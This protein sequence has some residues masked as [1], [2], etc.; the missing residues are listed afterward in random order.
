MIPTMTRRRLLLG[1]MAC[2]VCLAA[3][4]V[5]A[6]EGVPWGYAGERGPAAW[7]KLDPAY[8]SCGAGREQSPIDLDGALAAD[9]PAVVP[10]LKPVPLRVVHNGH[11]IEVD[12]AGGGR[13]IIGDKPYDL[14]QFH[15]HHPSEHVVAGRAFA[16]EMHLVH[17]AA[18]G[19][20]AVLGVLIDPGAAHPTLAAIWH[21]MPSAAGPQVS[22]AGTVDPAS[23][24]PG[25]RV[26]RYTGSLTT[27]PCT[28]I[29][30][31]VMYQTPIAAS[32]GQIAAF[33]ALFPNNARPAQSRGRRFL[34]RSGG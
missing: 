9:L 32:A 31:W 30:Q 28:E 27:P 10:E 16:M 20:I 15:F 1:V 24:V 7:G 22:G 3:G 21:V 34:L 19:E 23:L 25:G 29:V 2:P 6:A 14:L 12:G 33:A 26:W 8:A 18:D 17:R 11:T 13:T 4:R 5:L